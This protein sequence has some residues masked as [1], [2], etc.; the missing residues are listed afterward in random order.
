LSQAQL[1]M[2]LGVGQTR[3]ARI[4]R[5]P[6]AI[7]VQQFLG[8]LNFLGVQMVLRSTGGQASARSKHGAA[9]APAQ[10]T[11]ARKRRAASAEPW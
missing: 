5:D 10:G 9:S 2:A 6:A 11:A 8:V 7:S 1:G 3:V 4:E